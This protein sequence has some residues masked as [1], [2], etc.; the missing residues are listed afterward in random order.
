MKTVSVV[1]TLIFALFTFTASAA[2]SEQGKSIKPPKGLEVSANLEGVHIKW[3]PVGNAYQ[4][5]V[6]RKGPGEDSFAR[7]ISSTKP[8]LIDR[9]MLKGNSLYYYRVSTV[10]KDN[11]ESEKSE[12]VKVEIPDYGKLWEGS[13]GGPLWLPGF[14]LR[15]GQYVMLM[16][17]PVPGATEYSVYRSNSKDELGEK[18]ATVQAPP[19]QDHNVPMDKDAF[20]VVKVVDADGSDSKP[21]PQGIV[22]G[23]KPLEAPAFTGSSYHASTVSLRWSTVPEARFYNVYKSELKDGPYGL[24]T[25]TQQDIYVDTHIQDDGTYYYRISSV[26]IS[27]KES[28]RSEPIEIIVERPKAAMA[29][30]PS[31]APKAGNYG[32]FYIPTPLGGKTPSSPQALTEETFRPFDEV[33]VIQRP[34]ESA[35]AKGKDENS[36]GCG[37]LQALQPDNKKI[38]LPLKHTDV[39]AQVYGIAATVEVKQ[40]YHNPYAEKIEAVYVFP[41]PQNAAVSDF[42][43]TIGERRIRGIIRDKEEA[44]ELYNQAKRQGHVASLLTQERPNIFTQKVANIEPGKQID[45]N[46]VYFNTLPYSEGEYSF[47]FPMVVGPRYNPPGSTEGIGAV[48]RGEHGKSGQTTEVQYLKPDERSGHDISLSVDLDAGV[49]IEKIYSNTH[50]IEIDSKS[51]NRAVVNIKKSD[52]FP[53]KDFVLRWKVAGNEVKT[54]LLTERDDK[55]G[56]F[57]LMIQP[58]GNLKSLPR[59]PLEMIFV[60]DCSGSMNGW[61]MSKAKAAMR[62][63][64]K[65][66]NSDDTFQI[67]RF[68]NNASAL[69]PAPLPA[70]EENL[71]KGLAYVESLSG[72]GGTQMI[73]GIRAALDFPHDEKRFRIVSFMTDGFIGNENVILAAIQEKLGASRIFSFGVGSSVNRYLIERMAKAGK[74]AVAFITTGDSDVEAVDLFYERIGHPGLADIRIDWGTMDVADVYPKTIPDLFVGRPIVLTGRFKG[75][76]NAKIQINGQV[77]MEK[78]TIS[79]DVDMDDLDG[80]RKGISKIWARTKI[81]DLMDEMAAQ[82]DEKLSSEV[83]ETALTHGLVSEYTAFVAVD[84]ASKTMGDHGTTVFVPVPM[85]EG[86]KY[87][88]TVAE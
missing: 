1:S 26:D 85:P 73:E 41:L 68:S 19:F 77:S 4:Y 51:K 81:A 86:V 66:L 42:I 18:I 10:T 12:P 59:T 60:L 33:W 50:A 61:P 78:Q 34:E 37:E 46:I 80:R 28:P 75:H 31:S 22:P 2:F 72:S 62:R 13:P 70:T 54:A 14:P 25:S 53:N 40:Q 8:S 16:W 88:N 83:K 55:G 23:K 3:E 49:S 6:Y 43:M 29:V 32:N 36:L 76:G 82:Y 44:K 74:G 5:H 56:Y 69:G 84:S 48:A 57:T 65:G 45:I 79:L 39:S 11:I 87:E 30:A 64:L 71:E 20:Y 47:V 15:A 24:V 67:I 52:S 27:G 21:G 58:P 17:A 9:K 7:I 63:A 38:P 35:P